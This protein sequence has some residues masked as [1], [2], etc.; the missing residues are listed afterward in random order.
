MR[1]GAGGGVVQ[2]SIQESVKYE[3][4]ETGLGNPVISLFLG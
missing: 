3:L 4:Q 1:A 2:E